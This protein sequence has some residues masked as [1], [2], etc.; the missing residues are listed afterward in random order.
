MEKALEELKS[1]GLDV[2]GKSKVNK[3]YPL[4]FFVHKRF[5]CFSISTKLKIHGPSDLVLV[6]LKMNF[7]G[8][9][10]D[11][12]NISRP[13]AASKDIFF[14]GKI[15][16]ICMSENSFYCQISQCMELKY[17]WFLGTGTVGTGIF[18]LSTS[19]SVH[20]FAVS[21]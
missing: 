20:K 17:M 6:L 16:D 1:E 12:Q 13:Q 19:R 21:T 18:F 7:W 8:G 15:L 5:L 4:A 11:S 2:A 9:C 10:N 14:C 3:I